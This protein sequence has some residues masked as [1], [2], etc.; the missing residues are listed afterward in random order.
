MASIIY[1]TK[2]P[3][4]GRSAIED[5]YYKTSEQYTF[6]MRCGFYYT[7]TIEKYTQGTIEYKEE[8]SEGHGIFILVNKDGRREKV[9]FDCSLTNVQLEE[10]K[11]KLMDNNVNQEKSYLVTYENGVFTILFGNPPDN[12]HLSFEK[13]REK[14]FLKFG[15]PEYDFM[16]PIEE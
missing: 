12:F 8:K 16:V 4:C 6:C 3:C 5:Y 11:V 9:A 10:L 2:C 7:K 1:A 14:M 13:Y 15:V